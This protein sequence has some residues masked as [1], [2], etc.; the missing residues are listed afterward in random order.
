MKPLN[1]SQDMGRK[2]LT[3]R[4]AL[5]RIQQNRIRMIGSQKRTYG[6]GGTASSRAVLSNPFLDEN[7]IDQY[8]PKISS[9][10]AGS[11]LPSKDDAKPVSVRGSSVPVSS[12]PVSSL[13]RESK[14][15][16]SVPVSIL[17]VS[18]LTSA[19]E[20]NKTVD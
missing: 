5:G 10:Q 4:S 11:P 3:E 8:M 2:P 16:Q 7:E 12:V 17:L 14:E 18:N 19:W 15:A 13:A 20:I 9:G 6:K 1:L